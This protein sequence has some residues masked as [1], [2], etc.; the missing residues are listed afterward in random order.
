MERHITTASD[1]S[2]ALNTIT[3]GRL[4]LNLADLFSGKNPFVVIK[5]SNIPGKEVIEIP[6]LVFGDPGQP[7]KKL[8]VLMTLTET[9][10]ELAGATGVDAIVAHHPIADAA[11]CGGVTLKNYLGLYNIAAFE[12]HEAFHGLHP[13]LSLLH[14][15]RAFRVEIAYGG[16]PGNIMYVGKALPEVKTLGDM[17][18][19]LNTLM[20]MDE[21]RSMLNMER[22]VR[23][24]R[25]MEETNVATGGKILCGLPDSTV[26]TV[27]HIFP[28]TG[29]TP[30]QMEQALR[31]HPEID[32]VI[33][34]ISRVPDGHPLSA[35]AEELGLNFVVGNSHAMEISENGLPL[36][37]ALQKLLPEVEVVI[38]RERYTSTPLKDFGSTHIQAYANMIA[39]DYLLKKRG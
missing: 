31:E 27:L 6:G 20:C 28:H 7:V 17:L 18:C 2:K 32:T 11:S 3:G 26:E 39:E 34:S 9:A 35:K 19:R 21:E 36:A 1:V 29:F 37:L 22:E 24:C 38:Y 30:D 15:H 13:G 14:G 23:N 12:L 33:A 4:P 10:I 8:A 25:A 16:I 5:S